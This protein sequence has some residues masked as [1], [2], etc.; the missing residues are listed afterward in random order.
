MFEHILK[1]YFSN[2]GVALCKS[3]TKYTSGVIS[4]GSFS[5]HEI[6]R[7]VSKAT[8][9]DFNTSKGL[10]YLLNNDKLPIDDRYWRQHINMI[11]ALLTEQDLINPEEKVYIQIDFTSNEEN[12][13][14]LCASII[15]NNRSV[16][17]YFTMRNYPTRQ[18]Q[19][20]HKKMEQAFI[21]GLKH[22]LSKKYSYVIVADQGFA[23]R[24]IINY[25]Q[26]EGFEY[27]IRFTPNL[28]VQWQEKKGIINDLCSADGTYQAMFL[29][30][31]QEIVFH[32]TTNEKGSWYLLSN[33]KGIDHKQ[34]ESIYQDRFKIE[35]CFQDLK[36]SGF[37]MEKSKI[38]KYSNYKK[39]LAMAM[40]AH[41]LL[42]MLG[43]VIAVKLP[44]FLKNSALMADVILAYFRWEKRLTPYL[45]NDNS[46]S[47]AKY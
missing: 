9:K 32:H 44:A 46:L 36:S 47:H 14:I 21:K 15:V 8:G 18:G 19:Y 40:V 42:V 25:C 38:K 41:V 33:M 2:L 26:E 17:L 43:H 1:E 20:D 31:E 45:L 29:S 4:A 22:A 5:T 34:A 6:A 24:R 3:F 35:K 7:H 13:L 10:S 12:F 11:F 16:P 37:N 28:K 27:L 30:W 39:L 23:N